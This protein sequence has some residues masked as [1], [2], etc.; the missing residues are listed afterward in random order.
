MGPLNQVV[1]MIPGLNANMIPKGREKEGTNRI[2]RFL[3]MMDSMTDLELDSIEEKPFNDTRIL[4]IAK[5]SGT[6]PQEVVL[7][8]QEYIKFKNMVE[9]FGEMKL[10]TPNDLKEMQRNPKAM[11]Q[12]MQQAIDPRLMQQLGGVGNLMN[13]MKEM[14]NL[15]AGEKSGGGGGNDLGGMQEM[16]Q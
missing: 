3:C 1:S 5:G 6:H 13:M 8:I 10:N 14:G 15:E 16:M 11:M 12:K 2:K 9:K 7:L 4:R